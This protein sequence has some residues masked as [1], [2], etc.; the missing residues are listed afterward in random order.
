[1]SRFTSALSGQTVNDMIQR[2]TGR[3]ESLH[4]EGVHRLSEMC[5]YAVSQ[6]LLL[7]KSVISNANKVQDE[8]PNDDIVNIDWPEDC[9]E[10]AKIIRAKAQSMTGYI[11]AVSSSF[12]TGISDTAEAYQAA[13]KNASA[14]SHEALPQTTINEKVKSFSQHFQTDQTTAV[15]KIIDGLQ[16]LSYVVVSTSMPSV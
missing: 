5:C 11:E 7:G 13:I 12:T 3:L 1:M 15:A 6:L 8:E 16:Y 14:L 2:T 4:S 10:K 9:V